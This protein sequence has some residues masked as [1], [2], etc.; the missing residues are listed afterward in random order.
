[1]SSDK[2]PDKLEQLNGLPQPTVA[3]R[4][5]TSVVHQTYLV[6]MLCGLLLPV[7]EV[8]STWLLA[9]ASVQWGGCGIPDGLRRVQD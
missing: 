2:V 1:M 9:F 6:V 8:H 3:P 5:T 7:R 4:E